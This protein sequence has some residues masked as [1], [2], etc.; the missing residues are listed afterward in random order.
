[1]RDP[2][3]TRRQ[4]QTE[5]LVTG[6]KPVARLFSARTRELGGIA[7]ML[8]IATEQEACGAELPPPVAV[9][10]CQPPKAVLRG[11]SSTDEWL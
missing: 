9:V 6:P 7:K 11:R 8:A 1:M 5:C 4:P 2:A 10:R 3:T